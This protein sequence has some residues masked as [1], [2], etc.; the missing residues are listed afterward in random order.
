MQQQTKQAARRCAGGAASRH[1]AVAGQ[2]GA[3]V[4]PGTGVPR[5]G[6]AVSAGAATSAA[7]LG[8]DSA[9]KA[10]GSG[11]KAGVPTGGVGSSPTISGLP[12]GG[13][14]TIL[15]DPPWPLQSG[16]K[17]YRTMSLARIKAL[18]VGSLAARDAHLWLWT[19]NA[20]LPRAYE[21]AEAW[22]FTVRSPLTWVKFRLGLGGRYQLRN[23]TEQLLFCTRGK[24]RWGRALSRPGSTRQF[25]STRASRLSSSPLSSG[26]VPGRTWSC[27]PAA[28]LSRTSPGQC[29]ATKWSL[30]S[31][32]LALPCR[33]TASGRTRQ[34]PRQRPRQRSERSRCRRRWLARPVVTPEMTVTARR[35][36]DESAVAGQVP[37]SHSSRRW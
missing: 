4:R 9:S 1:S 29:G 15:V 5:P 21:V 26:S 32:S 8:Q 12:P 11:R 20:L 18:P 23:A 2:A 34:M 19:T 28:D 16:E 24:P 27:S 7:V 10:A 31:A 33:A 3:A 13:F 14:A 36:C 17:H 25:K 37:N 30:T 35:S 6:G 22:G